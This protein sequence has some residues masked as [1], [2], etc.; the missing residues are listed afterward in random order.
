M[1]KFLTGIALLLLSLQAFSAAS[2]HATSYSLTPGGDSNNA[3]FTV[4]IN[5]SL[6]NAVI[7]ALPIRDSGDM[8]F[9]SATFNGSG[10]SVA[11]SAV[12]QDPVTGL[13]VALYAFTGLSGTA[14]IVVNTTSTSGFND[15][16]GARIFIAVDAD[17]A[18]V[19]GTGV[20]EGGTGDGGNPYV[21][22]V[23]VSGDSNAIIFAA[24]RLR[25]DVT[26]TATTGTTIINNTLADNNNRVIYMTEAGG[27]SVTI[28]SQWDDTGMFN[29]YQMVG[30]AVNGT[31]GGASGLLLRRRRN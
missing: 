19:F 17:T 22:D 28:G 29:I 24:M 27:A 7:A 25:A 14:E 6:G 8:A 4:T 20:G 31:S 15:K 21:A 16:T 26:V 1:K 11:D 18:N 5:A 30:V 9:S 3:S 2:I 13:S 10:I 12:S 23:T